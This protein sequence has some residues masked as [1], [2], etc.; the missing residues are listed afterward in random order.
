M[1]LM[2]LDEIKNAEAENALISDF[3]LPQTE[4]GRSPR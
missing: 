2:H 3:W 1:Q 4:G